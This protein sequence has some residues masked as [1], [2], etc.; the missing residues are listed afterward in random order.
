MSQSIPNVS[1]I[2]TLQLAILTVMLQIT[3]ASQLPEYTSTLDLRKYLDN[4][5][6]EAKRRGQL[7]TRYRRERDTG[8]EAHNKST[9]EAL[10]HSA[11]KDQEIGSIETELKAQRQRVNE[12]EEKLHIWKQSASDP[13]AFEWTWS[14]RIEVA[15]AERKSFNKELAALHDVIDNL[16]KTRPAKLKE[17]ALTNRA[18][19]LEADLQLKEVERNELLSING[20]LTDDLKTARDNLKD[21]MKDM[22]RLQNSSNAR[23]AE[24][25]EVKRK[26]RESEDRREMLA[27]QIGKLMEV[28][29]KLK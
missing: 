24:A 25:A 14:R 13:T 15:E 9:S 7:A 2:S 20:R 8:C 10:K 28:I 21:K 16:E 17:I 18:E 12:A 5:C 26:L 6:M 22:L 4:K 19:R 1:N 11:K 29:E 3:S 27:Q 23:F